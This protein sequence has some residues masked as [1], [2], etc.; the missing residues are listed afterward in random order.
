MKQLQQVRC[1]NSCP[2]NPGTSRSLRIICRHYNSVGHFAQSCKTNLAPVK[3]NT[4]FPL[5]QPYADGYQNQRPGYVDHRTSQ[6]LQPLYVPNHNPWQNAFMIENNKKHNAIRYH[7]PQDY[8][9]TKAP[10]QTTSQFENQTNDKY[11]ARKTNIQSQHKDYSN[12]IQN[13]TLQ[14]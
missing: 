12:V 4:I 13:H 5:V 11:Q 2:N 3:T 14:E 8:I 6:Y 10:Q 7:Y 1:P 9:C